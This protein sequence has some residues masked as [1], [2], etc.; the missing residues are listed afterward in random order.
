MDPNKTAFYSVSNVNERTL[1]T[2]AR[3]NKEVT[4]LCKGRCID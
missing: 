2:G 4:D 3:A 1:S